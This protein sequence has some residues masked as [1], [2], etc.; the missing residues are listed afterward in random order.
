MDDDLV[1]HHI[2]YSCELSACIGTY[3]VKG[4]VCPFLSH[5]R[6][7]IAKLYCADQ[8]C[9][10]HNEWRGGTFKVN[11]FPSTYLV[12]VPHSSQGY[13]VDTAGAM[14]TRESTRKQMCLI[15]WWDPEHATIHII[16]A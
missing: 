13:E 5:S 7:T 11:L 10:K 3:L 1:A 16:V 14:L 8:T 6:M 15:S 4:G 9:Q 12:R 2:I